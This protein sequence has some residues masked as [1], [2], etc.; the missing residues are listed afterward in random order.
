MQALKAAMRS[1]LERRACLES[2]LA[3]AQH[4]QAG[5]TAGTD[6]KERELRAALI[7]Q[8][9]AALAQGGRQRQQI[10]DRLGVYEGKTL[11]A[12]APGASCAAAAI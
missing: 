9:E 2:E 6:S 5:S 12:P 3:V 10:E 8:L 7:G 11:D 4:A 1:N